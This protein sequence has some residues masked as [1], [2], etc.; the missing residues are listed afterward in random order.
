MLAASIPRAGADY[1]LNHKIIDGCSTNSKPNPIPTERRKIK[2]CRFSMRP[3]RK[4]V[5]RDPL[6]DRLA[7]KLKACSPERR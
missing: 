1:V 2:P 7:S 6:F 5:S 3:R 4:I